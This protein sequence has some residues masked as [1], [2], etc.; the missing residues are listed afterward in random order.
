MSNP[1]GALF[2][3]SAPSGCGKTSVLEKLLE[4]NTALSRCLTYT[5]RKPRQGEVTG[6]DYHFVSLKEF[7]SK[8]G[9]GFFVESAQVY[10]NWYGTAEED[11]KKLLTSGKDVILSVDVQGARTIRG[12]IDAV[13]IFLKPPSL[14]VLKE[15]LLK[16]G[17]ETPEAL[18]KRFEAVKDELAHLEFYDYTV[19]NDTIEDSVQRL[20]ALID[21]EKKKE[22]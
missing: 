20:Q 12:K 16:R 1:K 19:T 8:K 9:N 22:K 18:E 5:T 4:G 13:L 14:E 15:R 3:L 17:T 10:G 21:L 7:E 2:V 6:K 11:L